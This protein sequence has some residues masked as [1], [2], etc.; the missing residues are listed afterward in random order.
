MSFLIVA[1]S[2]SDDSSDTNQIDSQILGKWYFGNPLLVGLET[3][4]SFTFNTNGEVVYSYWSGGDDFDFLTETGTYSFNGDIM[5]MVFPE[6]VTLTFVQRVE[7]INDNIVEFIQTSNPNENAYEGDYFRDGA[8]SYGSNNPTECSQEL[9]DDFLNSKQD[10]DYELTITPHDDNIAYNYSLRISEAI[11]YIN[12]NDVVTIDTQL[13][14]LDIQE[15][16]GGYTY[17]TTV[18]NIGFMGVYIDTDNVDVTVNFKLK[19]VGS[20]NPIYEFNGEL[21]A[22]YTTFIGFNF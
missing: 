7:F 5:T 21:E 13:P 22:P 1:C 10:Y 6:G 4:N 15:Q 11:C 2:S 20:N 12:D 19:Q 14:N 3:N 8:D 9:I 18:K 17:N 16:L